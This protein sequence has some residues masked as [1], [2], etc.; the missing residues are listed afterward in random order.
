MYVAAVCTNAAGEIIGGG[1]DYTT[2]PAGQTVP[3]EVLNVST[4]EEPAACDLLRDLGGASQ[5][6]E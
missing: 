6:V 1:E 5:A 3:V 2:V 4:R